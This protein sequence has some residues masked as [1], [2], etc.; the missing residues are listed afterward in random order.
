MIFY[1]LL[2]DIGMYCS[3]WSLR[4]FILR[5]IG[6]WHGSFPRAGL[7][8]LPKVCS[9]WIPAV[10]YPMAESIAAKGEAGRFPGQNIGTG[11]ILE[12]V[13]MAIRCG[14]A[15]LTIIPEGKIGLGTQ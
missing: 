6:Y 15:A 12:Y 7:D 8:S 1:H 9:G 4:Q 11:F 3:S 10:N 14:Y 13:A 2:V 5:V